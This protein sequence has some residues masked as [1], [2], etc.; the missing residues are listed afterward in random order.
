MSFYASSILF[1]HL[2]RNF[3]NIFLLHL[4]FA[5]KSWWKNKNENHGFIWKWDAL[6]WRFLIWIHPSRECVCRWKINIWVKSIQT[7]NQVEEISGMIEQICVIKW[8][9]IGKGKFK[10]SIMDEEVENFECW[11]R[12]WI[13]D[14]PGW[15]CLLWMY[16]LIVWYCQTT[17]RN[18]QHNN[19]CSSLNKSLD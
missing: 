16:V 19:Q 1:L 8:A 13:L 11:F 15:T 2:K 17:W 14:D 5:A 4:L 6:P 9:H 12:I 3:T 18:C 7:E 10:F